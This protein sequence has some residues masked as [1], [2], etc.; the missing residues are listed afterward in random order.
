MD[1]LLLLDLA[2]KV[3][4]QRSL[5]ETVNNI[6]GIGGGEVGVLGPGAASASS[7]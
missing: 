7:G 3:S 1:M 5:A 4:I 2:S 6:R